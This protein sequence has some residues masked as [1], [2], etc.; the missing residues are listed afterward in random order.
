M[1]CFKRVGLGIALKLFISRIPV[2]IILIQ[3][4]VKIWV[5]VSNLADLIKIDE[6]ESAF[7]GYT[8]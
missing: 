8:L 5:L 6:I 4:E 2:F 7:K 1:F 3:S